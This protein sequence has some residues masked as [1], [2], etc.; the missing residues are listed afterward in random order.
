MKIVE[1]F[2]FR[3]HP[4]HKELITSS[5][6]RHVQKVA[7][8]VVHLFKVGLVGDILDPRLQREDFVVTG[9][10]D[11]GPELQALGEVHGSGR[12]GPGHSTWMGAQV[13]RGKPRVLDTRDCAFQLGLGP[14]EHS[15]LVRLVSLV[16]PCSEP[17]RDT[18][19]FFLRGREN[20]HQRLGSIE[21]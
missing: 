16:L 9:G 6:A 11:D 21:Y 8:R 12:D 2:R 1:K 20:P 15:D 3:I 19:R 10:D 14:D 4:R 18:G 17:F 13:H 5:R 7:F